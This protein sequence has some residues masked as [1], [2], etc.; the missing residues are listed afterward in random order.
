MFR[1]DGYCVNP[2]LNRGMQLHE[3]KPQYKNSGN[4]NNKEKIYCIGIFQHYQNI[5]SLTQLND[6]Q[7][8]LDLPNIC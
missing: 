5:S 7:E 6:Y 2:L 3:F 1:K 8:D 4:K